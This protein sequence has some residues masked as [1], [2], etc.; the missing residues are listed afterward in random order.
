MEERLRYYGRTV[1]GFREDVM[2]SV[3]GRAD[4]ADCDLR[5]LFLR[6]AALQAITSQPDFES[7]IVGFKR[8]HR[9]VAKEAWTARNVDAALLTHPTERTL[10]ESVETAGRAVGQ[11]LD[12]HDYHGALKQLIGLKSPIDEF[13]DGVLVNAPE[14]EVRANRLSLLC[15]V[16]DLFSAFGDLSQIQVQGQ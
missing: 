5:D 13:F 14:P 8:A 10:R 7:L 12:V 16:D 11:A 6:M 3:L 2:E 1:A 15:R 4:G 9:I